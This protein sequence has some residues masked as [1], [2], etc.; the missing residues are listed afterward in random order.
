MKYEVIENHRTEYPNPILLSQGEKVIIGEE[1][2][3]D[4]PN[5][6]FCIK[7]DKSN[8]GWVPKQIIQYENDFGLVLE[9]YSAKEL[10]IDIGTKVEG[11][12]K[13]NGWLW[14]KNMDTSEIGWVPLKKL[15][16]M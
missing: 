4:W 13:L 8:S 15:E 9:N 16:T 7:L 1:S 11:I 6:V 3:Q 2:D 5:W 12:K 10:D 14:L